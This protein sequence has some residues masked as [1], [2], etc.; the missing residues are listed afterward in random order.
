MELGG[1]VLGLMSTVIV[2]RLNS[3]RV[4]ITKMECWGA[5]LW[6]V[7]AYAYVRANNDKT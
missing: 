1:V 6:N 4:H 2:E 5:E 7:Y 3:L